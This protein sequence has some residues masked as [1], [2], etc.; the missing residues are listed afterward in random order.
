[1]QRVELSILGKPGFEGRQPRVALEHE[2]SG[3]VFERDQVE[4]GPLPHHGDLAVPKVVDEGA[5]VAFGAQPA[6]RVLEHRS[7]DWIGALVFC[8][9]SQSKQ[10]GDEQDQ[11]SH[12]QL[13]RMEKC[14]YSVRH[15]VRRA[16]GDVDRPIASKNKMPMSCTLE[17]A[18]IAPGAHPVRGSQRLP[19]H[20]PGSCKRLERRTP[21][22]GSPAPDRLD[23]RQ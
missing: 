15:G 10:A 11:A 9:V 8:E 14:F 20:R 18:E 22:A 23:R 19:S 13:D 2:V 17:A 5:Q 3:V 12:Q 6:C 7:D 16:G 21:R 4:V 1:M